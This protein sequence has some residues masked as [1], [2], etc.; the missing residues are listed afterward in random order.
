VVRME[1]KEADSAA[2]QV[3]VV[4]AGTGRP[5]PGAT[6]LRTSRYSRELTDVGQAGPDGMLKT[7][8]RATNS[9]ER[10][11]LFNL[12]VRR[13]GYL[14]WL[15]SESFVVTEGD[16]EL[17]AILRKGRAAGVV[18]RPDGQP[19]AGATVF[20]NSGG[21]RV[22]SYRP[23]EFR[24]SDSGNNKG[25]SVGADGVF[26]FSA[27]A[28]DDRLIA[29]DRAGFADVA[30]E[31]LSGSDRITLQ[32]WGRIEGVVKS[33]G[34][35]LARQRVGLRSPLN[36]SYV[37]S[38]SF[39]YTAMTDAAGRFVFTNIPPG[40]HL[41][42][43][44]LGSP[45]GGSVDS[46]RLPVT[47]RPGETRQVSYEFGGRL[48]TGLVDIDGEVDWTREPQV[49]EAKVRPPPGPNYTGMEGPGGQE[50]LGRA[51][52]RSAARLNYER[53]RQ[54]F[55][56][57]F[58]R[59]GAFRIEDVPP[60][61]YVLRLRALEPRSREEETS[62]RWRERAEIASLVREIVVPSG[63]SG[64]EVDLG[65]IWVQSKQPAAPA[66]KSA[67]LSFRATTLDG[68]PFE[69]SSER[70]RPVLV[71]FWAGWAPRS[72]G[73]FSEL[74]AAG[75]DRASK[76]NHALISVCL[77]EDPTSARQNAQRLGNGWK[78]LR[79]T[80]PARF[81][82]TEQLG[83]E[84]LPATFLLDAEGSVIAR[85]PGGRRVAAVLNRINS[86]TSSRP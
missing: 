86:Q 3:K 54:E 80:G 36:S 42:V 19:A 13:E 5:V 39:Q 34:K 14:Q 10:D 70:G 44:H 84:T 75:V 49:L 38:Y 7:T 73:R 35:P 77:D 76:T 61:T 60:G 41:L 15:S 23:G 72:N 79:L 43:R 25:K 68:R 57:V 28:G 22:D 33:R 48:V 31:S 30:V 64:T 1:G 81:E 26:E 55:Q 82:I 53:K 58:D 2:L 16:I 66:S 59:D 50:R 69:L 74:S 8:L 11:R 4:E 29:V 47:V 17:T 71:V 85:D 18:L 62:G 46:H 45:P 24:G 12:V 21:I 40:E 83:I 63:A 56:L 51:H 6:V 37:D 32:P 67:P 65:T 27:A 9:V 20:L 78:H 52:A